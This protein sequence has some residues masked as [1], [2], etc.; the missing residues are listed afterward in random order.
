MFKKLEKWHV[1]TAIWVVI[2]L[3]FIF[4]FRSNFVMWNM[5][6]YNKAGLNYEQIDVTTN[7]ISQEIDFTD[8][9]QS[10]SLLMVNSGK[11]AICTLDVISIE[12]QAIVWSSIVEVPASNGTELAVTVNLPFSVFV[13]ILYVTAPE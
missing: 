4:F 12:T 5:D 3:V 6:D 9:V 13:L 11:E 2:S 8:T 1:A 10:I 7:V